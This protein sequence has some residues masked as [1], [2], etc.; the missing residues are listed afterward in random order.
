MFFLKGRHSKTN[1]DIV[2]V[3]VC[4]VWC[5]FFELEQDMTK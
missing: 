4:A 1:N 3:G 2:H 5:D